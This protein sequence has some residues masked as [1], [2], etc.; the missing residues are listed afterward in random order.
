[1]PKRRAHLQNDYLP[2]VGTT[3]VDVMKRTCTVQV[4]CVWDG[5]GRARAE[6][7]R[8]E[9]FKAAGME[10][11]TKLDAAWTSCATQ[12]L[13]G[14]LA[15]WHGIHPADAAYLSPRPSRTGQPGL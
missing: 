1:M 13:R 12:P 5:M 8:G 4:R 11:Q 3:G 6:E 7:R 10:M 2:K 9:E 14:S 15:C